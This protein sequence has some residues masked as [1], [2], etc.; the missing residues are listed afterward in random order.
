MR[1]R[2]DPNPQPTTSSGSC[3]VHVRAE[4]PAR[5]E[6]VA[7]EAAEARTEARAV[8]ARRVDRAELGL[9]LGLELGL[10]LGLPPRLPC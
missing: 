6:E 7:V 4:G 5:A 3:T 10:G 8:E 1:V 9:G 2:G